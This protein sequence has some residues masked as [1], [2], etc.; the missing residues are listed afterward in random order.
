VY[1]R[2]KKISCGNKDQARSYR[3]GEKSGLIVIL[4]LLWSLTAFAA[5]SS[6]Y[7][8]DARAYF[9]Q[10]EINAAVIQLKNALLADPASTEARLLLG[11]AYLKQKDGLSAEKELRRAQELG[12]S[13]EAVLVPLG[14]AL[15]MTGQNDR[16]LET[17]SPEA[18]DTKAL[19]VDILLLQAQ[20][21][22]ATG[23]PAL[24]DN[25]FSN[26]L[27]LAPGTVE[28]LLGKARI[29]YQNQDTA[30]TAELVDRALSSETDNADAWT[31]KG[32]LLR[33]AGQQ[34][35]AV[36]A[37]K[38]AL[39]IDPH[40][41][42][43]RLGH[44][45]A[46]LARG[47]PEQ[48]N[49]DIDWLL[50]E[51][52]DLYLASYLKAL[53]RYQQGQLLPAQESIQRALKQA[54]GH[55]PSHLLAGTIAYQLE[56][57]NQAEQHLRTYWN[58]NPGNQQATLLLGATLLKLKEPGKAIEV[59]EPE[60]S[61]AA[62]NARYLSLMGRAYLKNGDA[63]RGLEYL[64]RAAAVAPDV[65]SI[66]TQLAIGQLAQGDIEQGV[67]ELQSAVDLGQ[68]QVQADVLLVITHLRHKDFDQALAATDTLAEKM[69]DSP[70]P[71][72]LKGAA[73]LG[74][75]DRAA[76]KQAFAAALKLQP[77][78]LPAHLNLAQLDLLAGDTAAAEAR[79]RKVLSYDEDN[80]D[81]LL[82]LA[83]LAKG[84]G[85]VEE[86]AQWLKQA[87]A[88]HPEAIQPALLLV[89]H[90]LQQKETTL[91]L[92]LASG[93]AV[94]HPHEPTVLMALVQTQLQAG[95]NKDALA[96]LHKL[97][98]A[99][100]RSP[101][102]HYLLGAVQIK[103][104]ETAAARNNLQQALQLQADYPAAQLL[105][106]RLSITD[107]DYAAALGI[108]ADLQQAH[109]DAAYGDELTGDVSA[110]RKEYQQAATAY[111][112]AYS[113]NASAL[114]AQKL[115]QSRLQ[116]GETGAAHEALRQWLAAHPEDV[117]TRALLAQALLTANQR[118]QAVEEYKNLLE[119]APDKVSALNNLAWLYQEEKNPEGIKY[120]ERAYKLVPNRPEVIDT[121]GWLLVQNGETNRGLVLLQEAATKAPHLPDIRYHMAAALEKAGRREEARK[122]LEHL[123][124]SSKTFDER[125][126]AVAL[127][128]Q[129]SD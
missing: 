58:S 65:A 14:R 97:V 55:L 64:E 111:A 68:D 52:P 8:R 92:D 36:T 73:L 19:K 54:P 75:D 11:K 63:T 88:L 13:R 50:K 112:L 69:P 31:L 37:F 66:R 40:N 122:E 114:L 61:A 96:T 76:A 118:T 51:Y 45:T 62:D 113:K 103:Q 98:E 127:R 85:Q 129:L 93:V 18:D 48:A 83:A 23:K 125:D 123:L 35:E 38:R 57:L 101:E 119:Y 28:A 70:L 72:N 94:A 124:K 15:L 47:E 77:E 71:L 6:E 5:D 22:L 17:T 117:P 41:V 33:T 104:Q 32:E 87:H 60:A 79:Y 105:L 86:T 1:F 46:L 42:T 21:C 4:C 99:A 116:A 53:V 3:S 39:D 24:A 81:A 89:Q 49:A 115:Y 67:G 20:A 9:D 25:K 80:L 107:K 120:A 16:L 27:K 95:N 59:L 100:P 7:L 106:G 12:A 44:A 2:G 126:K 91:A 10:G 34:Q 56:Q 109:P 74:K 90:Y 102:I 84:D 26:A 29:A 30:A 110:A 121:L 43:A 108:A 82:A 128:K 78:F